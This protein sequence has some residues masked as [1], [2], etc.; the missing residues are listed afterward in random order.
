[1]NRHPWRLGLWLAI[2]LLLLVPAGGC[3]TPKTFATLDVP[4]APAAAEPV[5]FEGEGAPASGDPLVEE[6]VALRGTIETE[7]ELPPSRRS[8]HVHVFADETSYR[9][10]TRLSFPELSDRRALF[11]EVGGLLSVFTRWGTET[12]ED[13]RH[14]VT[15][16]YLHASLAGLPLWL[17]EGLAEFYE[18]SPVGEGWN[19][20][21]AASLSRLHTTG[22]WRPDL[23]RLERLDRPGDMRQID[24]A[25]AWAWTYWMLKGSP[26]AREVL[27]EYLHEA[28]TEIPELPLS[29]RLAARLEFEPSLQLVELLRAAPQVP[30]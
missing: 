8:V 22:E 29:T 14:E 28:R 4:P 15:H 10:F 7:L 24:Y 3:R 17:D 26:E 27:L 16:G 13:L 20:P 9:E 23:E 30:Q 18:V 1:M 25:E 21:H 6:L 12:A 2:C 5:V 19:S 11:V